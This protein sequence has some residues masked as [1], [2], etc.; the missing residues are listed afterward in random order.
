[1]HKYTI[2]D[3]ALMKIRR[4]KPL[5]KNNNKVLYK[6][7]GFHK[8]SFSFVGKDN[9]IERNDDFFSKCKIS[10]IGNNNK[11]IIGKNCLFSSNI[12]IRTSD[13]HVVL[14][15]IDGVR[16]NGVK[17]IVVGDNVWV[18]QNVAVLKG[19]KIQNDSIIGFGSI[20]SRA[21]DCS[22]V[23]IARVPAKVIKNNCTR[24]RE[25]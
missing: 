6:N 4:L 16:I 23:I 17:D 24:K 18:C 14:S 12:K 9:V 2:I 22:N 10:I 19:A 8:C 5:W 15:N 25:R 1:M 13:S 20:V 21:F 7:T 3:R 11:I